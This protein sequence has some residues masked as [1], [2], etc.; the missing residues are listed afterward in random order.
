MLTLGSSTRE[1]PE[2]FW[3][4]FYP[5][6]L[7]PREQSRS[8]AASIPL[9]VYVIL[10]FFHGVRRRRNPWLSGESLSCSHFQKSLSRLKLGHAVFTSVLCCLLA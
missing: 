10:G 7:L 8:A 6:S 3:E 4:G 2:L 5:N 1:A 9:V